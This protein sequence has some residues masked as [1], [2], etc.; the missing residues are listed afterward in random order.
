MIDAKLFIQEYKR[1][2]HYYSRVRKNCKECP[3][4]NDEGYC[5]EVA[6]PDIDTIDKIDK[7]VKEHPAKT[8]QSELLEHYPYAKKWE[9]ESFIG[10]CPKQLV[11]IY[12][13]GAKRGQT[14][15]EC[16]KEYWGEV[17]E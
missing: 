6:L 16:C 1:M 12:E 14:C 5:S 4:S 8:R 10:I 2:C 17:V 9:D 15:Y 7:W 13:C 3:A 11:E